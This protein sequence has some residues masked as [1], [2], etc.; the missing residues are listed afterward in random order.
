M[1]VLPREPCREPAIHIDFLNRADIA[2]L[3]LTDDDIIAAVETGLAMQ[4]GGETAIEPRVHL[5]PRAGVEGHF[6][7][8]RGWIG[9][10]IGQAGVKIVG[11]YVDNYKEGRPSGYGLLALFDPLNGAPRRG[12]SRFLALAENHRGSSRRDPHSCPA[13]NLRC[14]IGLRNG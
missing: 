14:N 13:R 7:V 6:N 12:I 1:R 4:G 8:L 9:G 2:S 5:E 11:D 3:G 10:N